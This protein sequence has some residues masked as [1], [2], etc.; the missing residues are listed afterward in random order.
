MEAR[1]EVLER[2]LRRLRLP[3]VCVAG[4][5]AVTVLVTFGPGGRDQILRA[6]G[7]VNVDEALAA[8][9]SSWVPRSQK[10]RERRRSSG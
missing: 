3:G 2:D 9:G 4:V 8:S 7:L 6:R 5:L 1:I 10:R